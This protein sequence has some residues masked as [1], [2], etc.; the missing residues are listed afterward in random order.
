MLIKL[1]SDQQSKLSNAKHHGN[2]VIA[3]AVEFLV[4]ILYMKV[5]AVVTFDNASVVYLL[6]YCDIDG[7]Q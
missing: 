1:S 6:V 7:S 4:R 3:L 2:I 5:V